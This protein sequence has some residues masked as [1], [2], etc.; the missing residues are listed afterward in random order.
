VIERVR[1][2]P[3]ELPESVELAVRWLADDRVIA[4]PTDT[5]YGLGA[6]AFHPQAVRKLFRVKARDTQK[7]IPLL[8]GCVED[9]PLVAT[10]IPEVGWQL[11]RRFWPGAL[12]MVLPKAASV[13]DEL[14]GGAPTV[15]VRVPDHP[16]TARLVAGLGAPLAATSANLSGQ[17]PAT[18]A[19]E[20]RQALG[21]RVHLILDGGECRGKVAST[22]VDC[23]VWPP[24]ILRRGALAEDVDQ[25]LDALERSAGSARS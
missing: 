2:L 1:V 4:F 21:R 9:L 22:V 14:T 15:A 25:F 5:V 11:A 10:N 7:A 16:L 6:H 12:T 13:L 20:V 3:A 19:G 8:L 23:T 18:T 17:P 24:A